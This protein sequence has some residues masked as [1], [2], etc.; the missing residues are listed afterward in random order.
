M[1]N[2][3]REDTDIIM[4]PDPLTI[5]PDMKASDALKEMYHAQYRSMPVVDAEG[6]F[7][8]LF[9]IYRLIELLLPRAAMAREGS[10]DDLS[11]VH[12]S[13]DHLLERLQELADLPVSE[14]LEKKKRLSVCK[15]NTSLTEMLLLLHEGHTSLPVVVVKGKH[16]RLVGIVSHWDVLSKL[17][18]QLFPDEIEGTPGKELAPKSDKN[19][20]RQ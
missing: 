10:L 17:A 4:T 9:S 16:K 15:P 7:V 18:T 5:S 13:M 3:S 12:E 20:E 14:L 2:D 1:N 6:R 8:G 11:F 19:P